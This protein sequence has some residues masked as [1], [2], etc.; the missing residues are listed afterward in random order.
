MNVAAPFSDDGFFDEGPEESAAPLGLPVVRA[1]H[2]GCL[3]LTILSDHVL[4]CWTHFY[5]RRTQPCMG[6]ECTICPH[7]NTRRWYGWIIGY[8]VVRREKKLMEIPASVAINLRAYRAER[9]TLR[10]HSLK[11]FR[12]NDKSNGPV[13]GAIGQP[14]IDL[15]L[16]PECPDIVSLLCRLWQIKSLTADEVK[17]SNLEVYNTDD[18]DENERESRA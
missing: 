14:K 6:A 9:S 17:R 8:D 1:P 10:G 5:R 4:G 16:L 12:K 7:E 11:L 3:V 2:K 15:S 13:V 18:L